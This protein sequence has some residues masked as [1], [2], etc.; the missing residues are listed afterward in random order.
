M[1]LENIG[2]LTSVKNLPPMKQ[3]KN[4][5]SKLPLKSSL[6]NALLIINCVAYAHIKYLETSHEVRFFNL[7]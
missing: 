7:C 1:L 4:F 6:G 5:Y 2:H 3:K